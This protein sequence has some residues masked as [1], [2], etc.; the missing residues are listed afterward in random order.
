MDFFN[1]GLPIVNEDAKPFGDTGK[2]VKDRHPIQKLFLIFIRLFLKEVHEDDSETVA[3]IK[4]L[5][6]TRIRPTVQVTTFR[7]QACL[8]WALNGSF[9]FRRMVVTSFLLAT[10]TVWSN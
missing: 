2:K 4:E 8:H 6:D 5:L 10:M 7:P 3:L 1:S 9:V